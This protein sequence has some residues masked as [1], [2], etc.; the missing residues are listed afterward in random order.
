MPE[1]GVWGNDRLHITALCML[2]EEEYEQALE[3]GI[4]EYVSEGI[5]RKVRIRTNDRRQV[6]KVKKRV[7]NIVNGNLPE[8]KESKLCSYCDFK[9]MCTTKSSLASKLF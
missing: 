6:L 3:Y 5:V 8:K 1:N 4:V 7:E 2:V 9:D